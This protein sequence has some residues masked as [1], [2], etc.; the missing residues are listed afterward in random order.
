METAFW[1]RPVFVREEEER[2]RGGEEERRD[3][4]EDI[5]I[6]ASN[7]RT[8]DYTTT[9]HRL[10]S[11]SSPTSLYLLLSAFSCV[12]PYLSHEHGGEDLG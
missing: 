5:F 3:E 2:R 9:L 4:E 11:L 10:L 7:L 1:K 6:Y 12:S 8:P